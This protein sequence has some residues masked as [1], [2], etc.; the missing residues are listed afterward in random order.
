M[1]P[2]PVDIMKPT[3]FF[4]LCHQE[5]S[6]STKVSQPSMIADRVT[7]ITEETLPLASPSA[8]ST[9]TPKSPLIIVSS[10]LPSVEVKDLIQLTHQECPTSKQ[11]ATHSITADLADISEE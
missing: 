4:Q 3:D 9:T 5:N 11:V 1:S 6:T 10:S 7:G 8:T 2:L